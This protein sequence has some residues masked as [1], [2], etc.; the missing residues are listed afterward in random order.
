[1]QIN[2]EVRFKNGREKFS[3]R[4]LEGDFVWLDDKNNYPYGMYLIED[5]VI[6]ESEDIFIEN[7][8]EIAVLRAN[9]S[10]PFEWQHR[11][12]PDPI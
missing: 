12:L 3:V 4:E 11:S 8:T 6:V 1:M 5:L 7:I 10:Q 9:T 2:D